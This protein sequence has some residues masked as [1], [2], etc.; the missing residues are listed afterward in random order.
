MMF[1][2]KPFTP[3]A[4]L[5]SCVAGVETWTVVVSRGG[6]VYCALF[7]PEAPEFRITTGA[8]GQPA[9]PKTAER[10]RPIMRDAVLRERVRLAGLARTES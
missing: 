7:S 5:R 3:Y 8:R 1:R 4:R 2:R 10:L 9:A 6:S